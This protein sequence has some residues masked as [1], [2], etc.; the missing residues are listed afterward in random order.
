M[1][2][3]T[4]RV[5][6]QEGPQFVYFVR[7]FRQ[8]TGHLKNDERER[9]RE[10]ERQTFCDVREGFDLFTQNLSVKVLIVY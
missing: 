5:A 1:T 6:T 9:E 8:F 3:N 2:A 7:T 4:V 10:K